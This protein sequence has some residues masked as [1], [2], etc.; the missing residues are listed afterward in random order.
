MNGSP[1]KVRISVSGPLLQEEALE[2][3]KALRV[4]DFHASNG[5]LEKWKKRY[6]IVNMNVA[7][8]EGDVNEEVVNSWEERA[9]ELVDD[10]K[11]EDVWNFDETGLMWRALPEKS[12]NEK[13]TRCRGGKNSKY[14]NTWPFFANVAG[15]KEDPIVIRKSA[16]PHC[17]KTLKTF[18]R[19][20]SS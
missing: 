15:G 9:Q 20:K 10:Y 16:N 12:L 17:F 4:D 7:G 6:N 18:R 19:I 1:T 2:I 8:E 3:A 14:R 5:W 13:R 11:P